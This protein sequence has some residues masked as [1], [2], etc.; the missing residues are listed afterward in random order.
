MVDSK[1][2]AIYCLMRDDSRV[3]KVKASVNNDVMDLETLVQKTRKHGALHNVDPADLRLW[4]LK[5]PLP[6]TTTKALSDDLTLSG[7]DLLQFAIQLDEPGKEVSALFPEEPPKNHLHVIVDI[8]PAD[9]V[10]IQVRGTPGCGKTTLTNLA[11]HILQKE[12]GAQVTYVASGPS[13]KEM[14]YER[15]KQW[16][17]LKF[18]PGTFLIVDEAQSSYRDKSFWL[19]LKDINPDVGFCVITLASYGSAGHNI[20]DPMTPFHITPQQGIGLIATDNGDQIAV[21]LL[22]TKAEFDEVVPKLLPDHRFDDSFL[23]SVFDIT[24]GHV[25][26]CESFLH[27]VSAHASYRSLNAT[28]K[29]YT[30]V[31]FTTGVYMI[32]LLKALSSA[33]VFGR[34]LPTTVYLQDESYAQFFRQVIQKC[35]VVVPQPLDQLGKVSE[36]TPPRIYF[37]LGWLHNEPIS[38]IEDKAIISENS[39]IDFVIAVICKFI[40]LNLFA[41][42]MFG[43]TTQSTPEAQF[44][45]EFYRACINHTKNCVV[46]FPEFG[47]KRSLI[48]FLVPTKKWGIELLCNGNRLNAHA[49]R[50]TT[51][52]YGQWI[53]DKKINDY[54][55]VDFR[56]TLPR[57]NHK[58]LLTKAVFSRSPSVAS[59]HNDGASD[60]TTQLPRQHPHRRLLGMP[61]PDEMKDTDRALTTT[62]G[63]P[64]NKMDETTEEVVVVGGGENEEGILPQTNPQNHFIKLKL[65]ILITN[66]DHTQ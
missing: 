63:G 36:K 30:H 5:K 23:D 31:D 64:V 26:A 17:K 55:I 43:T 6:I 62:A 8:Q 22:L 39:I 50:F 53:S 1:F 29:K 65:T 58:E 42:R 16:L 14:L 40:P 25:G 66:K 28:S 24:R 20:Y 61:I 46:T 59:Q 10:K 34:R 32:D 12:P 27:V 21:G 54:V 52:E 47:N 9:G 13:K 15:W 48:D 18:E 56:T 38:P 35:G 45:D 57:S 2:R 44:Q 37:E 11:A 51:G 3:F 49:A 60:E 4:Q 33:S 41:Q 19:E 7:T